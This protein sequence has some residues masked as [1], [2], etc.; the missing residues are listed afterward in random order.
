MREVGELESI[1]DACYNVA[2]TVN[3][4]QL[5]GRSLTPELMEQLQAMISL[6][7]EALQ[8]M[9]VVMHGHRH[10]HS[11]EESYRIENAINQ[12]RDHLKADNLKA[13]NER[14]R[15]YALGS[16][17]GDLINGMEKLGDYVMNVV[18]AR[19]GK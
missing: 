11:I 6:C 14:N 18:E 7:D 17:F 2:R 10:E 8:Q 5:S 13:V 4:G 1:G 9:T 12:M 19:F 15:D 16:M 3:R